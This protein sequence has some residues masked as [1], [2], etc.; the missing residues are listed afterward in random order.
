[1]K[2]FDQQVMKFSITKDKLKMEMSLKDLVWLFHNSPNNMS[3][4][5]EGIGVKVRRGKRQEFAEFIVNFLMDE[6]RN[7]E[8][9]VNWGE[10]FENAFQEIFEGA[11]DEFCKYIGYEDEE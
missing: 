11:E 4:D 8:N 10:P 5:G 9:N 2:K 1:M 7:D 3:D 6:S